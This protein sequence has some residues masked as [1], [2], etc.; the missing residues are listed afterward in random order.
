MVVMFDPVK[1]VVLKVILFLR[2]I[3]SNFRT[4]M[5]LNQS[6]QTSQPLSCIG[7]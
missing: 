7:L 6:I 1:I 5:S 4:Y 2:D 3:Q